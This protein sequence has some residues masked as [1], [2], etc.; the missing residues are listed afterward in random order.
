MRISSLIATAFAA[1]LLSG[2]ASFAA[3][4]TAQDFARKGV[5]ASTEF[6]GYAGLCDLGMSIRNVNV[7]RVRS[8]QSNR[9]GG[10][11]GQ[12]SRFEPKDPLPPMQ[13]F[14][15][16][17]FL[18]THSVTAWLYGTA[19]GYVLIDGLTNDEEAAKV[20]LGGMQQL[21]LDPNAIR[22]VLVTH[23]HGDHYGGADFIA[24]TLGIDVM[25]SKPD[26]D[27]VATLGTHPRFGPAPEQGTT[28]QDGQVLRVGSSELTIHLAP[29][30]TPGTISPIFE[31]T[32]NGEPHMAMLWGGTGVQFWPRRR[33]VPDLCRLCREDA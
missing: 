12:R 32:D 3:G 10:G 28:V 26:W 27:L 1:T 33:D 18:G 19:E 13:V 24:E 30:H 31:V 2:G 14:D 17:Y 21:G 5:A 9:S 23:G 15:N 20:V 25:M 29:G 16:L 22:H 4:Q 8:Q 7:P 6:P 11:Q